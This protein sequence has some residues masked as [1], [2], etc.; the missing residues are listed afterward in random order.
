MYRAPTTTGQQAYELMVRILG[1]RSVRS[2]AAVPY[3]VLRRAAAG[4]WRAARL[5]GNR[6]ATRVT[7]TTA[8]R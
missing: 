3:A 1:D 7:A 5:A 6:A 8:T 4:S 2:S